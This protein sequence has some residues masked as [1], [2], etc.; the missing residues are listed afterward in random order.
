MR[1]ALICMVG[2][3]VVTPQGGRS[4][5]GELGADFDGVG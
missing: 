5:E 4:E 1:R 3:L 2:R